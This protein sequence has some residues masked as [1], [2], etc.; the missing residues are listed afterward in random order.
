VYV[1]F[2]NTPI[3]SQHAR[4]LAD[5]GSMRL[6]LSE[7]I[8]WVC[9]KQAPRG[10]GVYIIEK[11]GNPLPIYIGLTAAQKG[12]RGRLAEFHGAA[13]KGRGNHAG[14]R[15]YHDLFGGGL[16]DLSV[17]WHEVR[18]FRYG[19]DVVHAYVAY[20]ERRL[21]WEHVKA[22]GALPVCNSE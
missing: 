11:Q 15:T 12:L 20:V 4:A 5:R 14:G 19:A 1:R 2:S 9:R 18:N 10:A 22:H 13:T 3:T 21:I 16:T 7:P 6:H 17:H 8:D